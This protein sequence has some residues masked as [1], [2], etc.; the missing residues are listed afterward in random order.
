MKPR[1][2]PWRW[3]LLGLIALLLAGLATLPRQ[4]GDQARLAARVTDALSA[5]TGGQVKLTGPL[6]VQYF[7]D[8]SIKSGFEIT[9]ASRLPLVKSIS[10]NDARLSLDLAE[11]LFG[12]IKVDALR[13]LRPDIRLKE[14]PSLVTGPDQTLQAKVMNLLGGAPVGVVRLRGGTIHLPTADGTEAIKGIDARFDVSSGTGA[15]SSSGAFQL[16][17]E[18]VRFALESGAPS[19]TADGLRIPIS[20]TLTA[21]PVAA[22]IA[23]I[24]SFA[25]GLQLDGDVQAEMAS[26]RNFLRW[27]G[28]PLPDGKSLQHLSASGMS[29]WNGTTLTFDDGTFA[30]DGNEAVGALAVTPGPRPRVDGTLAFDRLV[31]DPYLGGPAPANAVDTTNAAPGNLPVLKYLDADLRISAAEIT[32]PVVVLGRGGFTISATQGLVAG[33]VGELE[34]CGGSATGRIGLDLSQAPA[35]ANVTATISGVPVEDCLKQLALGVPVA[36][37]A[38]LRAELSAEGRDIGELTREVTGSLKV[39]AQNGAVPVDISRLLTTVTPLDGDGW[40]RNSV[41]LFDQL[42]ANCRL[43]TGHIWCDT[44]TMQTGRGMISG[45]GDVDLGQ[46]TI[47]WNLFV[48]DH[49]RPLSASQLAT[50]SPP[51]ISISGALSQPMIRRADRPTLGDGSVQTNPA[52][53]QV[54]PR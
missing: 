44:F 13:L 36:G 38:R 33:D 32:A 34:L 26:L 49:A 23:G 1:Q 10:T 48:A 18:T 3:L 47:D 46:Q 51:R 52:S 19:D 41:T 17:G 2:I 50:E 40:S 7:P 8:V 14:A 25:A 42:N 35:K 22:K 4:F 24:A 20:L 43:G 6:S 11:L 9:N 30:L 16:R 29:H 15:M 27:T 31:L 45:S 5:W 54:S 12:R 39:T 21:T 53:S 37:T 28:V